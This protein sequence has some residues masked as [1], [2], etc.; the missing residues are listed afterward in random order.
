MS[1]TIEVPKSTADADNFSAHKA[2]RQ[3]ERAGK[4][5]TEKIASPPPKEEP[6]PSA[7]KG[8]T[9]GVSETPP[10]A[11][12]GESAGVSEIPPTQEQE[13]PKQPKRDDFESRIKDLQRESSAKDRRLAELEAEN[14]RLKAPK[15]EEP[16]PEAKPDEKRLKR[17]E[18]RQQ[19]AEKHPTATIDEVDDAYDEYV[20]QRRTAAAAKEREAA[21]QQRTRETRLN[22]LQ[23]ASRRHADFEAVTNGRINEQGGWTFNSGLTLSKPVMDLISNVKNGWDAFYQLASNPEQL[24]EVIALPLAEQ[25]VEIGHIAKSLSKPANPKPEPTRTVAPPPR[26][27]GGTAAP[28]AKSTAEAGSTDQHR[29]MRRKQRPDL[30]PVR[31]AG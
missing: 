5:L 25:F 2:I 29:E 8:E 22:A 21:E 24:R 9:P 4:P 27:V 28:E 1:A 19:Y 13:K 26:T 31:R 11:P 30:F 14:N 12:K 10:S 18:F 6:K 23:E 3:A 20:E 17:S 7:P 16:K 15:P